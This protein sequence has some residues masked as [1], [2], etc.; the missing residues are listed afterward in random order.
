MGD[1]DESGHM[2]IWANGHMA[3][4]SAHTGIWHIPICI[5]WHK[6]IKREFRRIWA[7][8]QIGIWHMAY[9]HS[10][11]VSIVRIVSKYSI[12]SIPIRF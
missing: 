9:N 3:Y 8:W 10:H 12:V 4:G 2:D 6:G 1:F 7:Y 5:V 11:I